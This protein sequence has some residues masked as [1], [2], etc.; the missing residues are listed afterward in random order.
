MTIKDGDVTID[1]KEYVLWTTYDNF[2]YPDL[3]TAVHVSLKENWDKIHEMYPDA[4]EIF[5]KFSMFECDFEEL[6]EMVGDWLD[7]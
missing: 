6:K 3:E 4:D 1:G 2:K 7:E 5:Y